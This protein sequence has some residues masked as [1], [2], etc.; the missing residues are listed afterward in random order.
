MIRNGANPP[1]DVDRSFST[2]VGWPSYPCAQNPPTSN[3]CTTS[4]SDCQHP[5]TVPMDTPTTDM[6]S[7]PKLL[8]SEH[9]D[10]PT[11]TVTTLT[12]FL[13]CLSTALTE[14]LQ[15]KMFP[16]VGTCQNHQRPHVPHTPAL[17]KTVDPGHSDTTL[18]MRQ[19][20]PGLLQTTHTLPTINSNVFP[21]NNAPTRF[22]K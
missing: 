2:Y 1:L 5:P 20:F 13:T 21:K 18:T 10:V 22:L 15:Q 17:L 3:P 4:V 14:K 12:T 16:L 19:T 8:K 7:G 11:N 9:S 6:A